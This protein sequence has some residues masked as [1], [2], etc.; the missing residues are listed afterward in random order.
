MF[1]L[2]YRHG[3]RF[4]HDDTRQPDERGHWR[5]RGR[6]PDHVDERGPRGRGGLGRFFAQGD[7]RLLILHLIAEQPRH[8][9]QIIKEIEDRVA[10][11]YTPSP[12][13]IYPTLTLLEEQGYVVAVPGEGTRKAYAITPEGQAFLD[14]NRPAL[15]VILARI[16]PAGRP[17]GPA[18][19]V[20]R[21][22]QNLRLALRLR[23]LRGP[24]APAEAEA[25]AAA[26]DT[27]AVAVER[28]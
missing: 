28:T 15:D 25:I 6:G 18:P 3:R 21:A 14:A 20:M 5:G 11:A 17:G 16:D 23:L 1:H 19:Q 13:V 24:L 12:G 10:G 26:L 4:A 27:A 7:L 9:Y 22:M 8:G 2:P